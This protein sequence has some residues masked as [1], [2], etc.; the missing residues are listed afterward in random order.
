MQQQQQK[1]QHHSRDIQAIQ[2]MI[3]QATHTEITIV[4]QQ[5]EQHNQETRTVCTTTTEE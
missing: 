5:K 3:N 1:Q 4:T 2:H